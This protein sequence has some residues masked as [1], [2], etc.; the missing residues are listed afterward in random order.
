[1]ALSVE[2]LAFRV[3]KDDG[4]QLTATWK[5]ALNANTSILAD[6]NFR[7]RFAVKNNGSATLA[8]NNYRLQ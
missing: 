3:R 7:I 6:T 8:F 1:M 2:Q 4:N 5:A